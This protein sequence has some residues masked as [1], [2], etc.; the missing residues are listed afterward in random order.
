MDR[1]ASAAFLTELVK[2]TNSPCFLL[3]AY[4]D[5]GVISMTDAWRSVSYSGR[6]YTAN[7]HFLNFDGLTE[8]ADLQVPSVNVSV[9][10]VDQSWVSIALTKPYLDRRLVIYKAFLDYT[11][12]LI[13]SPVIM[14]D[15]RLDGM[16]ISDSPDGKCTVGIVAT[17]LWGDFY[18]KP[19]R[20]TNPQ[21]QGVFFPGDRFFEY[22]SNL[23]RQIKWGAL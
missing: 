14:F 23:N 10:S 19:G 8:T 13:S 9:S 3:D 21:E 11:Q 12:L 2:S 20:H 6:T 22:C 17:S 18:R 16:T 4:F 15:G 1:G 5:D 7:G